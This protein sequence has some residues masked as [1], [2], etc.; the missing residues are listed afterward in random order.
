MSVKIK[1]NLVFQD[2]AADREI[3][4][5][6]GS[7]VRQC[8]EHLTRTFP[9]LRGRLFDSDGQ[10]SALI[11]RR[12]ET[13]LPNDLDLPVRGGEELLLLPLIYGG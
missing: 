2:A 3:I 9:A 1:L 5:V 4:E 10:L 12:G 7:T 6:E 11:V 8:L 13:L